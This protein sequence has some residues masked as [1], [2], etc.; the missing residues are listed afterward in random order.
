MGCAFCLQC[1]YH[2]VT[3]KLL[4]QLLLSPSPFACCLD[5]ALRAPRRTAVQLSP[6]YAEATIAAVHHHFVIPLL[7][8]YDSTLAVRLCSTLFLSR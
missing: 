2:R 5:M 4:L 6:C 1:S 7:M 3:R 8:V